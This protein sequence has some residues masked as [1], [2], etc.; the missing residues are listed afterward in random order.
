[1]LGASRLTNAFLQP[2]DEARLELLVAMSNDPHLANEYFDNFNRPERQLER[3]G[4]PERIRA[5]LRE[6]RVQLRQSLAAVTG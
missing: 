1:M 4:S 5:W 6:Q 2:P 3:V